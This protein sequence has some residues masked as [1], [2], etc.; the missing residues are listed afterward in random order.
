MKYSLQQHHGS[1][2]MRWSVYR[3]GKRTQPTHIIASIRNYKR[4][5]DV[6]VLADAYFQQRVQKSRTI[7]AGASTTDFMTNI[8]FPH[9]EARLSPRTLAIYKQHWKRLEPHLGTMRLR[10]VM[11]PHI[12]SALDAIHDERGEDISHDCY[13]L[14]KVTCSAIFSLAIRRGDHPGPNPENSTT[15]RSYGHKEHRDNGAYDLE[16][17]KRFFTLFSGDVAVAIAVNAFL[18]LRKPEVEALSPDDFDPITNRV[19]IHKQTKTGN[20]EWLPVVGPLR[21]IMDSGDWKRINMRKAEYLIRQV[22][23]E[24]KTLQWKGWYAFRRGMLTNL[25]KLGVR[26]VEAAMILRNSPE[27]CRKHYLRL[28]SVAS[29]QGTMETLEKAYDEQ[30]ITIK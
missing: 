28:D 11:T 27:V 6:K 26:D 18:A 16:E 15:V 23:E 9:N 17:I 5:A 12:Q 7:Q 14:I 24:N 30:R 2:V 13:M 22:L 4:K 29:R 20:D 25:W 1:W 8:F 10:D 19:H 21:Q 3:E